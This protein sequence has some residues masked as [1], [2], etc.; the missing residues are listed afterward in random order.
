V[1]AFFQDLRY[2]ARML[3]RKPSFTA[4]AV[5]TLGLGIGANTAIFSVL[6]AALFH[7]LPFE[8]PEELMHIDNAGHLIN[9]VPEINGGRFMEWR[10]PVSVFESV[11]AYESGSVNFSDEHLPD[12]IQIM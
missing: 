5:L 1:R 4:I 6:D 12:R 10:E 8:K 2:G 7:P 11:A 9:L 3:L